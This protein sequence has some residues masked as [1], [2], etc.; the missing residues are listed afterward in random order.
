MALR[1]ASSRSGVVAVVIALALRV[2]FAVAVTSKLESAATVTNLITQ[3]ITI[4]VCDGS[5]GFFTCRT[6]S[7]YFDDTGGFACCTK[8]NKKDCIVPRRCVPF[9]NTATC[10]EGEIGCLTCSQSE[11]PQCNSA[12]NYGMNQY[13]IW[14]G[15]YG[16]E[17]Y[18]SYTYKWT[19][20][21]GGT[22]MM[23]TPKP[24]PSATADSA[25]A[26][27]TGNSSSTS[28]PSPSPYWSSASSQPP[29]FDG[30][31]ASSPTSLPGPV[32]GGIAV[33]AFV[34]AALLVLGLLLLF[35]WHTK[36]QQNTPSGTS[37]F[38]SPKDSEHGSPPYFDPSGG[39]TMAHGPGVA[40]ELSN[41]SG[42]HVHEIN[43]QQSSIPH[44]P[45][46]STSPTHSELPA[47]P[48]KPSP[49][50]SPMSRNTTLIDKELPA[51]P[52]S[53]RSSVNPHSS[54]ISPTPIILSS[55][56]SVIPSPVQG[57]RNT[58]AVDDS[59]PATG[60]LAVPNTEDEAKRKS[61]QL[62]PVGGPYLT[63][64]RMLGEG[65][66]TAEKEQLEAD[67]VVGSDDEI[68]QAM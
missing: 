51:T 62:L 32:I 27:N 55:D 8:T 49:P 19:T 6:G 13:A 57:E 52:A 34:G 12:T 36:R 67:K 38:I 58:Y 1:R 11:S 39:P 3:F 30:S 44:I 68:G 2:H 64:D 45:I 23:S 5:H 54:T 40:H 41:R 48:Q 53:L 43:A 37:T 42:N 56:S 10:K 31:H 59:G 29:L 9:G 22:L 65:Y 60:S 7:C 47:L 50:V 25:T 63:A 33:G 24:S 61:S 28:S 14:C 16:G 20:T 66:W 46:Y 21:Y 26:T 35:K 15:K 18:T 4:Q 17:W